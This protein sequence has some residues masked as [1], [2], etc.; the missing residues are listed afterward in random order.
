[1]E[2]NAR[3]RLA[4]EVVETIGNTPI[5]P[6]RRLAPGDRGEVLAKLEYMNPGGSV[7]DRI[8]VAMIDAA[9]AEGKIEPATRSSSSRP[10]ATRASPSRWSAPPAATSSC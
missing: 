6:L 1:M 2:L 3:S 7:K 9:E 10:A 4:A 5:V 8:G